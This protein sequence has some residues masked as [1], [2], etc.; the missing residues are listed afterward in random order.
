M[1]KIFILIACAVLYAAEAV[2]Q[3]AETETVYIIDGE[4]ITRFD[5]SQLKGKTVAEYRVVNAKKDGTQKTIHMIDTS[6]GKLSNLSG[7]IVNVSGDTTAITECRVIRLNK[8]GK[9]VTDSAEASADG[10]KRT[11]SSTNVYVSRD[12]TGTKKPLIII[13]G[14]EYN[15]KISDI[16]VNTIKSIDVYKAGSDM[17]K[18]YAGKDTV[19]VMV[20]TKKEKSDDFIFYVNG[21][22]VTKA[23]FEKLP[24]D[25]IKSMDIYKPGSKEAIEKAGEEG[26]KRCVLSFKMK[27]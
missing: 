10:R 21:I 12:S 19:D 9:P 8:D 22:R 14:K 23:D 3:T 4:K 6:D 17:A 18:Q 1:K 7:T 25:K 24:S 5:G 11:V 27:L 16:N 2:S 15:G 13:D 26:K 20:V